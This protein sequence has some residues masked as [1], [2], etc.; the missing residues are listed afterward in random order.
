[1]V[2]LENATYV[3]LL[4]MISPYFVSESD[5]DR[6]ERSAIMEGFFPLGSTFFTAFASIGEGDLCLGGEG[7][8]ELMI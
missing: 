2:A 1:M 8:C 7:I 3:W 5:E 6:S 4:F